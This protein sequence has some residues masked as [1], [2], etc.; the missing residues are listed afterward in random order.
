MSNALMAMQ[1]PFCAVCTLQNWVQLKLNFRFLTTCYVSTLLL[2]ILRFSNIVLECFLH[3]LYY[4]IY[5]GLG[6]FKCFNTFTN[7][8]FSM[9]D[10]TKAGKGSL[11]TSY[12]IRM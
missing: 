8:L 3:A 2:Y 7:S 12:D 9:I 6:Y 11:N 5:F 1:F 4:N 10:V